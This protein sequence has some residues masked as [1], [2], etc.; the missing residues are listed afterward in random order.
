VTVLERAS[1]RTVA[2]RPLPSAI[3]E[4]LVH[5]DVIR[6][7]DVWL[8][9]VPGAKGLELVEVPQPSWFAPR[10]VSLYE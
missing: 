9:I 5:D 4:V 2:R 8:Q 10:T 7:D 1:G 6:A 3:R